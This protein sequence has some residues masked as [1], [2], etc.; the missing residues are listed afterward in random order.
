MLADWLP[1]LI[2]ALRVSWGGVRPGG[3]HWGGPARLTIGDE[4]MLVQPSLMGR[5]AH[6]YVRWEDLEDWEDV[7]V[8]GRLGELGTRGSRCMVAG[9]AQ[10]E[11]S[12]PGADIVYGAWQSHRVRTRGIVL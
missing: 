6:V 7:R 2:G 3:R 12:N 1:W 5:D 8:G 10:L 9:E 4:G 11:L